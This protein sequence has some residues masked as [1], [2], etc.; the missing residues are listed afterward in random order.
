MFSFA[1]IAYAEISSVSLPMKYQY[2][3]LISDEKIDVLIEGLK[4]RIAKLKEN[5]FNRL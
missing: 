4:L 5:L 1:R 3:S 2:V